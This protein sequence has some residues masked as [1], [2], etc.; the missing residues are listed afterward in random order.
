MDRSREMRISMFSRF[1]TLA[2]ATILLAG[3]VRAGTPTARLDGSVE[4]RA[5]VAFARGDYPTALPLFRAVAEQTRDEAKRKVIQQRIQTCEKAMAQAAAQEIPTAPGERKVHTPPA[6]GQ[7]AE[8]SIKELGNFDYDPDKGGLP[9]DVKKLN[10]IK[11]RLT[12]FMIPAAQADKVT[13]FS[14]VPSLFS[15]CFGRP[16]QVQHTITVLCADGHSIAYSP[17]RVVVEGKLT[18]DERKDDGY[19]VEI[20]RV[21]AD[22]VQ[23]AEK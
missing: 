21:N 15:C 5:N 22:S 10:G 7:V 9:E 18:V 13:R 20:F 2:L 4:S 14:L 11:I 6:P 23:A 8:M 17:D 12:G 1:K 19:V 16:P 3:S